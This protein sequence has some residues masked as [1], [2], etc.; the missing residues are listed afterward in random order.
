[1]QLI[2]EER[3]KAYL[4]TAFIAVKD[5]DF[6]YSRQLDTA[7]VEYL[8]DKLERETIRPSEHMIPAVVRMEEYSTFKYEQPVDGSTP[9]LICPAGMQVR[10]LHGRH[11]V[12]AARKL[13]RQNHWDGRWVIEIYDQA[14][15]CAMICFR[16]IL[17]TASISRTKCCYLV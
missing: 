16:Y 3:E 8:R 17:L 11:R 15:A 10:C 12:A 14:S 13:Q 9:T 7:H 4:E 5:L 1:M 2:A 6:P